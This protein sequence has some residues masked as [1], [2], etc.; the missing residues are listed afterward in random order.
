[1]MQ[2]TH[3]PKIFH[4]G[5]KLEGHKLESGARGLGTVP[6]PDRLVLPLL[7]HAGRAAIPTVQAGERVLG[8]QEIAHADGDFSCSLHAP[9]SARVLG[10]SRHPIPHPGGLQAD[11][12]VLEPDGLNRS[13]QFLPSLDSC[14][15][16]P[17]TLLRRVREAGIA[18][19]GGAVFPTARKL[20]SAA[21]DN[22]LT[23][24]INGAECEPYISCDDILMQEQSDDI[25][26]GAQLVMNALGIGQALL[27]IERDKHQALEKM[28]AAVQKLGDPRI[29][30]EPIFTI[31]PAGGERQ[32]IQVLSGREVPEDGLPIDIGF[33]CQ[34]VATLAAIYR[35]VAFGSPLISRITTVTGSGIA[36]PGNFQVLLGTPMSVLA[37]AAGGYTP[38]ASRLIMGGPMMGIAL[39][40]DEIPVV[41]ATN[42]VLVMTG[43]EV[44]SGQD[45]MPCIRCGECEQVCPAQLQPQELYWRIRG[46]NL[47]GA[48]DLALRACIECGCCDLVCPSHIP[49]SQHY[50]FAKAQVRRTQVKR[51]QSDLARQRFENRKLRLEQETDRRKQR[52]EE[53]RKARAPR[54]QGPAAI[55]GEIDAILARTEGKRADSGHEDEA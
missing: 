51:E 30:L 29:R 24:V 1:M 38:G 20:S 37:E 41:K 55:K 9:T 45:S 2:R 46:G 4:G 40:S 39:A 6:V 14:D 54:Q 11:C 15:L 43:S 31:Y 21:T 13:S 26:H 44:R 8:N 25:L 22:E 35:A 27:A 47:A 17:G 23:L 42:C 48:D 12:L 33:L 52:L 10:V 28:Q 34:N 3:I 5:L 16:D 32:L 19:L 49:L 36:R 7:Q 50:R 53:K 18:G